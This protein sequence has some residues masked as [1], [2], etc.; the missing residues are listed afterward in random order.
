MNKELQIAIKIVKQT[1]NLLYKHFQRTGIHKIKFKK[2]AEI[3]TSIDLLSN[4]QITSQLLKN[5]PTYDIISE[6]A[7]KINNPDSKAWYVDPLDG[8]TNFAYGFPEFATCLGLENKN[9]IL[10]GII[11]LPMMK[12]IYYAEKNKGAWCDNQKI[13]VSRVN[14]IKDSMF[15]ICR[16]HSPA[17][18]QRFRK[19]F[20]ELTTKDVGHF[21]QFSCAGIELA[22]VASGHA[23]AC[24]MANVHPWDVIAGVR[25]ILEAGGQVSNWQGRPWQINDQTLIASNGL[26]HK[27]IIKLTK[28]I[29]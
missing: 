28:N 8:T 4:R 1:N 25:I 27:E 23:E 10:A 7:K 12:E 11:G 18:R 17:G 15:L 29:K 5:F 6:E 3:V 2:D 20:N 14:K 22:A 13:K 24:I 26:I 19:F 16:G 9:E 21:R